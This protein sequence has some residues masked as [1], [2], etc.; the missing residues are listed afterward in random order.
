MNKQAGFRWAK[1]WSETPGKASRN[2]TR[3]LVSDLFAMD[4]NVF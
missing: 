4:L 3:T 2:E 1:M